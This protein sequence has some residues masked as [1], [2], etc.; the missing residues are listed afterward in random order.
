MSLNQIFLFFSLLFA[1]TLMTASCKKTEQVKYDNSG[2]TR[3][4]LDINELNIPEDNGS[5]GLVVDLRP[6]IKK[7]YP[8]N[9]VKVEIDGDL[10]SFSNTLA[11][12][13]FTN[14]AVLQI[15]RD[16]LS[17]TQ[18]DRFNKGVR[19]VITVYDASG[20]EV[21]KVN[22]SSVLY[23]DSGE[24]FPVETSKA[25]K[26]PALRISSDI[27]YY[28]QR[29]NVSE[30]DENL[31]LMHPV[32][33]LYPAGEVAYMGELMGA[34][35]QSRQTFYL[36]EAK[37]GT[38]YF[39]I[40][41][42]HGYYMCMVSNRLNFNYSLIPGSN[43]FKFQLSYNEKGEITLMPYDGG[44]LYQ[45]PLQDLQRDPALVRGATLWSQQLAG[46]SEIKFRLIAA[47]IEWDVRDLGTV[48]NNPILPPK[49]VDFA[50]DNFL[51]NCSNGT[52]N[53]SVGV[54]DT[55]TTTYSV[56]SEESFQLTSSHE[57]SVGIT[58]GVTASGA[59]GG[60]GVEASVEISASYTYTRSI[61]ETHT[62]NF[63]ETKQQEIQVSRARDFMLPPYSAVKIYDLV[64]SYKNI[65]IPFIQKLRVSGRMD[66]KKLTGE[67]IVWQLLTGQFG[68]VVTEVGE[69]H[70]IISVRG[71]AVMSNLMKAS[72]NVEEVLNSC[73]AR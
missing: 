65:R 64:E 47:D 28:I 54:Q 24:P 39:Y 49:K 37:D 46:T 2:F 51:R 23:N 48:Y 70:V 19:T 57:A 35:G 71:S 26:T 60:V 72:T 14:L 58:T 42:A 56:G 45:T 38:P 20:N 40:K 25:A 41:S 33:P 6:I 8:A 16:D 12:D 11:I 21:A 5:I 50:F 17:T 31:V 7:G 13:E 18:A 4:P 59:F 69:D 15:K 22:E 66:D 29:V 67:E 9:K 1:F 63:S 27:P 36:E 73:I 55:R 3:E 43:I 10:A 34:S 61:S 44:M 30:N 68:G 32:N 52:L 62:R 53:E